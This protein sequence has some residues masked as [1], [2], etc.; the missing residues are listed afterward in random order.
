MQDGQAANA[1]FGSLLIAASAIAFSTTGYFTR[2]IELDVP[3]L[4][5]WR[6]IFGGLFMLGCLS[7]MYGGE[8]IAAFRTMGRAGI[9]VAI[10]SALATVCYVVALRLTTV[11]EVLS[12]AAT[13][14]FLTGGLAWLLIG[15]KEH[16]ATIVASLF[17]MAG[18]VVMVGPGA[19]GGHVAGAAMAFAMTSSLAVMLVI[20]RVK[21][22]VSMLPASCLSAF[23]SSLMVWPASSWSIPAGKT[24][25]ELALFGVVQFGLG[26]IL[27]T[28][29]TRRITALRVSLLNRLQTVLGPLWVW[30]AFGEVPQPTTVAGG[31]MVLVSAIAASLITQGSEGRPNAASPVQGLRPA[32]LVLPDQHDI[33]DVDDVR[34]QLTED[35]N[36]LAFDE[37]VDERHR[38]AG[39]REKPKRHRHHAFSRA[40][41]HDPLHEEACSEGKLRGQAEG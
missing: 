27:F 3:T 29:G 11:A 13:G 4:L 19:F 39:Y 41:A 2:L 30:L 6:G 34:Q 18:V 17:A 35:D 33:A 28:I 20:M 31:A 32:R 5:F 40:F 7:L 9:A 38:A 1:R 37:A 22:S 24:L 14:P 16:W 12:I 10:L 26:L 15:E 23:L 25:V 21:K 8:T 36:G